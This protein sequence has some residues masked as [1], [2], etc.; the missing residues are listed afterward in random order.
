MDTD[1]YM[2]ALTRQYGAPAGFDDFVRKAQMLNYVEHRAMYEGMNATLWNPSSGRLMWMSHPS[3]P[4]SVWQIYGWNY[5]A[6]AS[7]YGVK[8]ACEPVHV[9]MNLPD[10]AVLVCNT[11]IAPLNAVRAIA[12]VYALD[13]KP[14][15][16]HEE[17][18]DVPADG[19]T[20][21]FAVDLSAAKEVCLVKL[22]LHDS[23]GVLLSD[24]LYWQA[25]P[26]AEYLALAALPRVKLDAA[27][28][29]TRDAG[30]TSVTVQLSNHSAAPALMALLC[31]RHAGN[32]EKILPEFSSDNYI[33]LLPGEARALTIEIPAKAAEGPLTLSLEGWNIQ[34]R[35]IAVK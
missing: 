25:P 27:P 18:L 2:A 9:Q 14:L 8:K 31:V 26:D 33:N 29:L 21:S 22:E 6:N 19:S 24:N 30:K 23:R 15:W 1:K 3:W 28:K 17:V 32:G 20:K 16:S 13:G 4:S 7:F 34:P 5:D 12:K 10:H 11:T 35:T